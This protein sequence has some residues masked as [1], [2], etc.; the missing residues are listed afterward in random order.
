M[1]LSMKRLL[2]YTD[3]NVDDICAPIPLRN[4]SNTCQ[5]CGL[6]TLLPPLRKS[7]M[8]SSN[9]MDRRSSLDIVGHMYHSRGLP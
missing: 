8:L 4:R 2:M 6:N 1:S 3:I 5:A 9:S 7:R